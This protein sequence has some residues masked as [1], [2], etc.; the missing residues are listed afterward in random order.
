MNQVAPPHSPAIEQ[1]VLTEWLVNPEIC[2]AWEPDP[3]LFM[4]TAEQLPLT[5]LAKHCHALWN[6]TDAFSLPEVAEHI[7]AHGAGFGHNLSANLGRFVDCPAL[8]DFW[9]AVKKLKELAALRKLRIEAGVAVARISDKSSL[10]ETQLEIS[11]A[12]LAATE[13]KGSTVIT[14]REAFEADLDHANSPEPIKFCT[15]G[16]EQIDSRT[17]GIRPGKVWMI[18]ADSH[19]GKCLGGEVS[20]MMHNG[21]TSLARDVEV[22]DLLMGPDSQ[23]RRVLSLSRGEGP[24]YRIS[25]SRGESWTCNWAHELTLDSC[26]TNEVRDVSV[27]DYL[28]KTPT[29]KDQQRL[30]HV[31]ID[32]PS[33]NKPLLDPWFLGVWYGDGTKDLRGVQV[34]NS[35]DEVIEGLKVMA[36]SWGMRLSEVR[37]DGE[38]AARYAI[39][40]TKGNRNPV[41]ERLRAVYGSGWGLPIACLQGSRATRLKFLAGFIDTDGFKKGPTYCEI[42]TQHRRWADQ[43]RLMCRSLGLAAYIYLKTG[44]KGYEDREYWRVHIYGDLRPIPTRIPRKQFHDAPQR[45]P[46]R[47]G[48][49]VE[50]IG[51]GEYFGWET[52]GDHRF[53]LGDLTVTHNSTILAMM[54]DENVKRKKRVLI[55][56]VE[57]PISD[58]TQRMACRRSR[59]RASQIRDRRASREDLAAYNAA[60]VELMQEPIFFINGIGKAPESIAADIRTAIHA[61]KIDLTF[62]DYLQALEVGGE[63][64]VDAL[65]MAGRHLTLA[66]K[67]TN[68]AGVFFSQLTRD[69]ADKHKQPTKADIRDCKDLSNTAEIVMLGYFD[70]SF[71]RLLYLDKAKG[72]RGSFEVPV[73][74]DKRSASFYSTATWQLG[75]LDDEDDED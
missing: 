48:F 58:Y 74:F 69:K 49:G 55:V 18:G 46:R 31:A 75:M 56:T 57:D 3:S 17:G 43:L 66:V 44:V 52:D 32:Y 1:S 50:A 40:G 9:K 51:D 14:A 64:R 71:E 38:V 39:A 60:G 10:A 45:D 7:R 19:W 29:W 41:L 37:R 26:R 34:T 42:I 6:G 35:D 16:L 4:S 23:P 61:H 30:F 12:L 20:V 53:L 2:K 25:P 68:T 11:R 28:V 24:M 21:R 59:V 33:I 73:E 8:G 67:E 72:G 22:G 15:S 63:K 13:L 54:A 36:S 47:V 62:F 70:Q 27:C 5:V 65:R